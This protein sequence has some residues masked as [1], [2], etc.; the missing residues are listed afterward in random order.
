MGHTLEESP[1]IL[2]NL[3]GTLSL[4]AP[5]CCR[6]GKGSNC[7][8]TLPEVTQSLTLSPKPIP[9]ALKQAEKSG[10]HFW[11]GHLWEARNQQRAGL[12]VSQWAGE[13]GTDQA[14]MCG[15][16]ALVTSPLK[17]Q[18]QVSSGVRGD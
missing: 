7:L 8:Q 1:L 5:L 6:R 9:F 3:L 10:R 4:F 12:W 17:G 16:Q 15:L 13:R 11:L 14:T 18:S 2:R